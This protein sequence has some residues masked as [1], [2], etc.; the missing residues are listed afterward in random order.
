MGFFDTMFGRQEQGNPN[1]IL[2]A[3]LTSLDVQLGSAFSAYVTNKSRLSV[4]GREAVEQFQMVKSKDR[5]EQTRAMESYFRE[6]LALMENQRRLVTTMNEVSKKRRFKMATELAT[7][8]AQIKRSEETLRRVVQA[9]N[10]PAINRLQGMG[11]ALSHHKS[12]EQ[13]VLWPALK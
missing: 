9:N 8:L 5:N 3:S 1:E 13:S 6:A 7:V 2:A 10:D 4:L 12:M 11:D